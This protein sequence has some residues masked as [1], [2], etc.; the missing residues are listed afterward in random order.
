M[1]INQLE[2]MTITIVMFLNVLICAAFTNLTT[3]DSNKER[4]DEG[5]DFGFNTPWVA[6]AFYNPAIRADN[7]WPMLCKASEDD[8]YTIHL[9]NASSSP[10]DANIMFKST[11]NLQA[12]HKYR[13]TARVKTT[14]GSLGAAT[15]VLAECEQSNIVVGYKEM[16]LTDGRVSLFSI[17]GITGTDIADLMLWFKLGGN[18]ENTSV[19]I[20]NIKIIDN[21]EPG[22]NLWE[23]ATYYTQ[24]RCSRNGWRNYEPEI[25]GTNVTD[26]WMMADFDDS[27]WEDYV[28]PLGNWGFIPEVQTEWRGGDYNNYWIRR[29]FTLDKVESS[30][31]YTLRVC[32]DDTYTL[33]VNGHEI[34]SSEDWTVGYQSIDFEIPY[35]FFHEGDN[36][37]AIYQQ[38]NV[39]GKFSDCALT[40]TPNKY[41]YDDILPSEALVFNEVLVGNIDQYIDYSYNYGGWVELYNTTDKRV[42]LGNIYISDDANEPRKFALPHDYGI[43]GPHG[44]AA[45][46]FDH[47]AKDG[48]Y[49]PFASKQVDFALDEDGGNLYLS[50]F[51]GKIFATLTYPASMARCAYARTVDGTGDWCYTGQPSLNASN[52]QSDFATQRLEAPQ[53]DTDSKLF[54]EPFTLNITYPQ[55]TSLRYT[56]DGSAPTESSP[57][58]NGRLEIDKN[59]TLRFRVFR[60][61]YLPSQVVT[62]TY[63]QRDRDYYLPVIAISTAA[64]NLY[65]DSIGVYV[66]GKN[67]VEGHGG[68]GG[69]RYNLNMDWERP[70]NVE[71]ITPDNKMVINQEAEFSIS[72][73]W[74]RLYAPSSFKLKARNLYENVNSFNYPFFTAKPYNKYKML[75]VRNG[76]NDNDNWYHGRVKDGIIQQTLLSSG[77][78]VDCQDFQPTHVFFNGEYIGML[79]LREP[80]TKFHGT[81]NYGYDKDEM[82]AFEYSNG[83][84]QKG[85]D[86][87]SF[88]QWVSLAQRAG[89]DDAW[90][91]IKDLVDIDE[92][93]NYM[94]AI[95]YIGSSDWICNN[96]N[97]KGYRNRDN[98]KFHMVLFDVDWGFS[99]PRALEQIRNSRSNDL[100]NIFNNSLNNE[101]FHRQF[102]DAFCLMGG[103]VFTPQRSRMIA[104]SIAAL[105][106]PALAFDDKSPWNSYNELVPQMTSS[107]NRQTKMDMLRQYLGM[108]QGMNAQ[109]SSNIPEA[110][111]RLNGQ[112]VPLAR[113]DGT[114]FAP[115]DLEA[116]AP[117]GYEFIGWRTTKSDGQNITNY[118][119]SWYYYDEGSLDG[120]DWKN[121]MQQSTWKKGATPIGYGKDNI[122]SQT[123]TN[124]PTYYLRKTVSI[125]DTPA[126]GDVY[127]LNFIAD[128]GF[129]VYVN[130]IEAARYLMPDGEITYETLATTFAPGNPDTGTISLD[131]SLFRKGNNVIAVELHNNVTSSSDIFWNVQLQMEASTYETLEE[132]RTIHIDRDQDVNLVAMFQPIADEYL[133]YDGATPVVVNEVSAANSVYANDYYKRNDWFELYN[134][135]AEPV[136][137]AGMYLSDD[138]ANPK[139]YRIEAN[140]DINTVIPPHGHLVVWADQLDPIR[141]V[142]ASFKLSNKDGESVTITAAD[143][144]WSNTLTYQAHGGE[145]SVGRYPDAGKRIYRMIR[146]TIG[147]QNTLTLAAQWLSGEDTDYDPSAIDQPGQGSA[148]VVR[149]DY[150]TVDGIRLS[151][152][153]K[154]IVIL[155]Q[156]LANGKVVSK[157]VV[158]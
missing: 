67:G 27:S 142:H 1:K 114:L 63:I 84:F 102:V 90:Q 92:F 125:A 57:R 71:Y 3:A 26:D 132:E 59:T 154:G 117:A 53:P 91:Q 147:S 97:S 32:H 87:K 45:I 4:G 41:D 103:S 60:K 104:D 74:S 23:G 37:I 119:D 39:G 85:G 151:Q 121:L 99:N 88:R 156:T 146:P 81:A 31:G 5:L 131:A 56:T 129:V 51:E 47:N 139:K 94:A 54:D 28:M 16:N 29:D 21:N 141:H 68:P 36:V 105:T 64:E 124:L 134:T 22:V 93:A 58:S 149:T 82:D 110:Q 158:Y 20:Y 49:G 25:E 145:E 140:S 40:V 157:K 122:A 50:D 48:V 150:Y 79:N 6:K 101:E 8:A 17:D 70:V 111:I 42:N 153:R 123:R 66:Q 73:G 135:T 86:N 96:N 76:G 2:R 12:S 106:E 77:I 113:F 133:W 34:A 116:S 128:D 75:L 43:I 127:M 108:G 155:R 62:R 107:G 30:T 44:Y 46:Y 98:G 33:Y 83:Y 115:F 55:G 18:A 138:A 144:S 61:G 9:S 130:G 7:T 95:T 35:Y 38:Q 112:Q 52:N 137:I 148:A 19:Q 136:D 11:V 126:A 15:L 100:I 72:G 65:D 69:V 120:T 10:D 14:S 13:V 152:P 80:S 118:G 109:I 89:D 143:E 78:Y 24:T